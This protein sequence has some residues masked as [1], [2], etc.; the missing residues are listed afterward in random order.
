[1]PDGRDVAAKV[2]LQMSNV[3]E[4]DM[5]RML[6]VSSWGRAAVRLGGKLT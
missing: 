2:K 6:G 5:P 4:D 3:K 1:M